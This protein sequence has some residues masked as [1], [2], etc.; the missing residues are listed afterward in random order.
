MAAAAT[1]CRLLRLGI[2]SGTRVKLCGRD[3]VTDGA[4]NKNGVSELGDLTSSG[5]SPSAKPRGSAAR[6]IIS[7]ANEQGG[8]ARRGELEPKKNGTACED[9]EGLAATEEGGDE[10]FS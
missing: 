7:F 10:G 6:E 5:T 2:R 1:D 4:S 9:D 3:D 8:A